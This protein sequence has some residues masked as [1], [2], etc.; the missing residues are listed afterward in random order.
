MWKFWFF[1]IEIGFFDTPNTF[2]LI[3]KGLKNAFFMPLLWLSKW[4]DDLLQMMIWRDR[5]LAN[6]NP[7]PTPRSRLISRTFLE[8]LVLVSSFWSQT[9]V[10]GC[11]IPFNPTQPHSYKYEIC[12]P[13]KT[14][15]L[16]WNYIFFYFSK[17]KVLD[18][19]K[20]YIENE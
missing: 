19:A 8:Q 5:P 18:Y 17:W 2:Y 6:D 15:K 3:V 10:I 9:T 7:L 13:F 11:H 12:C 1:F 16:K 4:G 20:Q 14:Y